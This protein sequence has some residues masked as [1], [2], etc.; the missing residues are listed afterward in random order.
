[1]RL[2]QLANQPNRFAKMK[3]ID[4]IICSDN[5][6]TNGISVLDCSTFSDHCLVYCRVGISKIKIEP[7]VYTY[8][9][10]NN[11]NKHNFDVD[12]MTINFEQIYY[13]NNVELKV[14]ILNT[15]LLDSFNVHA[16]IKTVRI[17]KRKARGLPIIYSL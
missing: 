9:D 17:S 16:P 1:M 14:K 4:L 7:I 6:V 15:L 13:L 12:L 2:L 3:A 10:F 8:R 5:L 11:F